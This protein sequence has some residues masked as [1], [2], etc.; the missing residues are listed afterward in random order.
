MKGWI[1]KRQHY[2]RRNCTQKEGTSKY[3]R[4]EFVHVFLHWLY[5]S[6]FPESCLNF[7]VGV[8]LPD[9]FTCEEYM[10]QLKVVQLVRVG[11]KDV[12]IVDDQVGPGSG[13]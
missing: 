2:G 10:F 5:S 3:P 12:L 8:E 6:R 1:C 7:F 13:V 11:G 4:F 9:F